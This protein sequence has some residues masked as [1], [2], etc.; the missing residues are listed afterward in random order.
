VPPLRTVKMV[1]PC[2]DGSSLD[3][4]V[5]PCNQRHL[6]MRGGVCKRPATQVA[7]PGNP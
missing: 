5:N 2:Q 3:I 7:N 6:G 1:V 4:R